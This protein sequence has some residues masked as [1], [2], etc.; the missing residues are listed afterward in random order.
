MIAVFIA[1]NG[2]LKTIYKPYLYSQT[3]AKRSM[4]LKTSMGLMKILAEKHME[5]QSVKKVVGSCGPEK[6]EDCEKPLAAMSHEEAVKIVF[7]WIGCNS[8]SGQP[9]NVRMR[10]EESATTYGLKVVNRNRSVY[11]TRL[12]E[13][14]KADEMALHCWLPD[15]NYRTLTIDEINRSVLRAK[16]IGETVKAVQHA[17]TVWKKPEQESDC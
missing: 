15:L 3:I 14:S 9:Y 6:Y 5:K 11:V 13:V 17:L 2:K 4:E 12:W 1:G 16:A 8:I 7:K 10:I